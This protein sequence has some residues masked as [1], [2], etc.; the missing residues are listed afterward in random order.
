MVSF[1][2]LHYRSVSVSFSIHYSSSSTFRLSTI[3]KEGSRDKVRDEYSLKKELIELTLLSNAL[4]ILFKP[5]TNCL[6]S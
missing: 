6:R 3:Y 5:C 4:L 2:T 1:D